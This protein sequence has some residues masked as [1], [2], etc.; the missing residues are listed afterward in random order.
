MERIGI[1]GGTFNPVHNGH[2]KL[3]EHYIKALELDRLLV[4]PTAMPPH[5]QAPD[6]LD[7]KTRLDLCKLA[8]ADVPKAQISDIEQRRCGKSYTIDTVHELY[9]EFPDAE[10]FLLCGSD[11][12]LTFSQWRSWQELLQKVT[13]CTAA[14]DAGEWQKL[15]ESEKFLAEWGKTKVFDFPVLPL[16]STQVRQKLKDGEDCSDVLDPAV[17]VYIQKGNLYRG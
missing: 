4:I 7:A 5:K 1:F 15:K 10:F 8:F 3:A 16:S 17:Y 9:K 11:M 12:F 14:R 13:L 6:L 2:K